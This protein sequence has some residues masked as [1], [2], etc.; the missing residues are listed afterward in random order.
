MNGEHLLVPHAA[1][2]C[3]ARTVRNKHIG[4]RPGWI[5]V[6]CTSKPGRIHKQAATKNIITGTGTGKD[7]DTDSQY[8]GLSVCEII[9][10]D[11]AKQAEAPHLRSRFVDQII[12]LLRCDEI[13]VNLCPE[14]IHITKSCHV[15]S[16]RSPL[17]PLTIHH[18][19]HVSQQGVVCSP[20]LPADSLNP[21]RYTRRIK[22]IELQFSSRRDK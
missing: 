3:G 18:G 8:L 9:S 12:A 14:Y 4:H 6:P 5:S 2:V 22:Y 7:T 13:V 19:Q 11:V 10:R 21:V 1:S 17:E 20:R 16:L 15:I